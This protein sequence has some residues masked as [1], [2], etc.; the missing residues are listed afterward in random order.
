VVN[1][2]HALPTLRYIIVLVSTKQVDS[3]CQI[4]PVFLRNKEKFARE[5][6]N[7]AGK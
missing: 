1:I 2:Y 3:Q 7:N 4:V 5:I 6:Q